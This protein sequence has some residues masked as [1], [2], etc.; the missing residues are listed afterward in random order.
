MLVWNVTRDVL[1]AVI[2]GSGL[3][4]AVTPDSH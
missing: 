2:F 3:G 1:V 4:L